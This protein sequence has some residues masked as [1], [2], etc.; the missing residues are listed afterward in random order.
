MPMATVL[1][2][3]SPKQVQVENASPPIAARELLA[4]RHIDVISL[5][6]VDEIIRVLT[7]N[8]YARLVWFFSRNLRA[9]PN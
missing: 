7:Y 3:Y 6:S 8:E 2:Y 9:S 4:S 1:W 5:D